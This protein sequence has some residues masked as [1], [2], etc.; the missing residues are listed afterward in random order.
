MIVYR[1]GYISME[2]LV[3]KLSTCDFSVPLA[4][5]EQTA[6]LLAALP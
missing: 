3:V 1:T 2:T 6:H 5:L 4:N